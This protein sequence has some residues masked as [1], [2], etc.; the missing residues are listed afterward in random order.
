[1]ILL[2]CIAGFRYNLGIDTIRYQRYFENNIIPVNEIDISSFSDIRYQPLFILLCSLCKTITSEFWFFQ[3]MHALFVNSIIFYFFK[4][5]TNFPFVAIC[6][7]GLSVYL[8][9]S[10]ETLRASCAV[11]MMLLGYDQ[12][13]E[14]RRTWALLFFIASFFFH[15]EAIVLVFFYVYLLFTDNKIKLGKGIFVA[16][17]LLIVITPF[18]SVFLQN[19]LYLFALTDSM[20]DKVAYYSSFGMET[21]LNWKGIIAGVVAA[22]LIPTISIFSMYRGN[23]KYPHIAVILFTLLVFLLCIPIFIFYRYKEFFTPFMILLMSDTFGMKKLFIS[24]SSS[25]PFKSF[26]IK[27]II[28]ILPYFWTGVIDKI[29][30]LPDVNVP[31]YWEYYPY[32]SIFDQ[33]DYPEREKLLN[34]YVDEYF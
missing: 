19:Y 31:A 28:I 30:P 23:I 1:M 13:K 17:F 8:G 14:G 24:K 20:G 9:Y 5:Y 12:F 7:Y 22:L 25:F 32:S 18:I 16:I 10:M 21:R 11:A 29:S 3:L 4:K 2:V 26:A 27:L 15:V 33:T 6:L 34:Y